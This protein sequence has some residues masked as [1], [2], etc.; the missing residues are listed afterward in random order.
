M[1]DEVLAGEAVAVDA[2]ILNPGP[3]P[4]AVLGDDGLAVRRRD[5]LQEKSEA[6]SASSLQK[7][8]L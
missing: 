8:D 6:L 5:G 2:P 1:A 7:F 4:S 3:E